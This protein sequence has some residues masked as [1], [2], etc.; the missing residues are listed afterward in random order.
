MSSVD[1]GPSEE[2]L[3]TEKDLLRH[4]PG[5][6]AGSL[7]DDELLN[8]LERV[9]RAQAVP[10]CRVCGGK[11]V[12]VAIGGAKPTVWAC[13]AAREPE[14]V[15]L[16]WEARAALKGHYNAS[17]WTQYPEENSYVGELVERFRKLRAQAS[18][19]NPELRTTAI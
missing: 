9:A 5:H 2:A 10:P 4:L 7:T 13:P 15:Y 8:H 1:A 11:L 14:G 6:R 16:K 12:V 18:S 3:T 19:G 17:Q